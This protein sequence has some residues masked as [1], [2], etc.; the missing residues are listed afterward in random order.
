MENTKYG[1]RVN[2][3]QDRKDVR[4]AMIHYCQEDLVVIEFTGQSP[5][6]RN[7]SKSEANASDFESFLVQELRPV[8][9]ITTK[10]D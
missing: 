7:D 4:R 2:P 5:S 6:T 9:S 10:S 3:F 1:S 8:N